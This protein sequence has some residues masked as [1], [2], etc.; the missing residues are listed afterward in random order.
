LDVHQGSAPGSPHDGEPYPKQP[1]EGSQNWSFPL[2]LEG[3]ELKAES[4]VLYR[5]S[6]MP[7]EEESRETKQQQ[8]ESRH[9]P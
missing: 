3:G 1:V 4:G 8:D 9:E 2:A 6:G 7:A 5:D